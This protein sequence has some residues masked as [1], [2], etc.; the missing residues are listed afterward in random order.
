METLLVV[1]IVVIALAIVVQAGVLVAMYM[2]AKEVTGNVNGLVSESK[3]MLGPLQ[4]VSQNVQAASED[5]V[6]IGKVARDEMHHVAHMVEE[7]HTA[8]TQ[9]TADITGKAHDTV[10]EI[11]STVLTPFRQASAIAAGITT[12]VRVFFKRNPK[13][14]DIET[15]AA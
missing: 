7:S 5:L 12:G 3:R 13:G 8:L 11:Q 9:F 10:D 15:P 2:A 4:H 6:V 1:A 14:T